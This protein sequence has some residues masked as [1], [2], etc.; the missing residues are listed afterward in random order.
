MTPAFDA[1][2]G[3]A[4]SVP[5]EH[6]IERRNIKLNGGKIERA[7]SCPRCGGEDRFSIN[8]AKQVFNC[9]GCGAKGDVI[10][11]AQ[12]LD[13][14]D[15][16]HAVETLTREPPPKANGKE[17]GAEPK[18]VVAA[19]F[20]YDTEHGGVAFVVERIEYQKPDGTFVLTKDGKRKKTFRQKRPDPDRPSAWLWNVDG[21]PI[22]PYRLPELIEALAGERSILIAEG[23]RK[24]D[25][26]R[27]WNV[28]ATCCAGGAG[29]WRPEH[30]D[31]LRGA[32]DCL[33]VPDEDDSGRRH[34][35]VVANS[36][37]VVGVEH[38]RVL[39]LPGLP[40]KGD[41]VDWAAAGGTREQLDALIE[42]APEYVSAK[43]DDGEAGDREQHGDEHEGLGECDAGD[44]TE[45]PP[46]RHWLL[47]N[48]FC[49][50]FLS[51]LFAPGATGKSALRL[52]QYLSLA[53]GREL[54]REHVFRRGRV[55][56]VSLE[57][58]H[59][60]MRRRILA[61]RL[62]HNISLDELKGWLFYATPKG[63]KLAEMKGGSRQI[64]LLEKRLRAAIERR[65][66]DLIGLD[67]FVKLHALE[68][69]DNGAM[70]FVADLLV[71]L[72]I[73]YDIGVDAPHHTKKGQLTPGDADSGRGASSMRDA[74]RLMYTLS[75]MDETE[76]KSFGIDPEQRHAY[77]RLDKGKVNLVPPA[78]V[79]TWFKLVGVRLDNGTADYPNGDEVQT[80]EPWQPPKLWDG[81]S[82]VTL[83]AAL[84][85]IDNGMPNGQRYSSAP[86]AA[87]RAAWPI[88]QKH[89][90]QR[91]EAQC[92]EIVRT[93]VS[94][95]VLYET[96]YDDPVDRRPRQGLRLNPA[97]RPS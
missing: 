60:E 90:Q 86:R 77:V 81:L 69:N 19:E 54:T 28:P 97:K 4:R 80:V 82:S 27:S 10:A 75:T 65:K 17:G 88:I 37:R 50:K 87:A 62:H 24:V 58:D 15:F 33:I 11:L 13:E 61:A 6:E 7:G 66:P 32:V 22:V 85:D 51:G 3:R 16:V 26:L 44:D 25:L 79:A 38:V 73:E 91:T 71:S 20:P 52:A 21:A 1:W 18:K 59:D 72:G 89:C 31:F 30:S 40:P 57:D 47:G 5:I 68:E 93:W 36:L 78:R 94:N 48:Q 96:D 63:L 64:G 14:V 29:K 43:C 70:D 8:T 55:L 35:D 41:I 92:R 23:E 49:R 12:F 53:T 9:R 56:V 84:T 76:A 39:N 34:V 67:P 95:G 45:K 46:P 2:V 42:A 83:N 74:G